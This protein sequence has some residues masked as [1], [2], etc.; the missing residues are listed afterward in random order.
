MFTKR[1]ACKWAARF[2]LR[3]FERGTLSPWRPDLSFASEIEEA[4]ARG[5]ELV[6]LIAENVPCTCRNCCALELALRPTLQDLQLLQEW[7]SD[8]RSQSQEAFV[9][10]AIS[11]L[12]RSSARQLTMLHAGA[13]I[14]IAPVFF[15][16]RFGACIHIAALEPHVESFLVLKLNAAVLGD[17][18]VPLNVGLWGHSTRLILQRLLVASGLLGLVDAGNFTEGYNEYP[19]SLGANTRAVSVGEVQQITGT[20]YDMVWLDV[21]AIGLRGVLLDTAANTTWL[22]S[23]QVLSLSTENA[24]LEHEVDATMLAVLARHGL[25]PAMQRHGELGDRAGSCHIYT[26]PTR[27]SSAHT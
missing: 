3:S 24:Q 12:Q 10:A 20:T 27:S 9:Q 7:L 16:L 15:W 19:Y 4:A 17:A 25:A 2:Q 8:E 5:A 23:V 18:V 11:A 22:S 21:G 26:R 13:R 14:G 1:P 6:V